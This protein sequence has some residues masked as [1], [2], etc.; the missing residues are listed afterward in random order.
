MFTIY[1]T[2]PTMLIIFTTQLPPTQLS[3][4]KT[5]K[6]RKDFSSLDASQIH[7]SAAPRFFDALL[8]L[9]LL[10]LPAIECVFR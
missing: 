5:S 6:T 8:H 10:R 2:F 4:R 1:R 7:T 3:Y 9:F